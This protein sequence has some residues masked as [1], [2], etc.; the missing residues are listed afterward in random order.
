MTLNF[1]NLAQWEIWVD[2]LVQIYKFSSPG[3]VLPL[4]I[5]LLDIFKKKNLANHIMYIV[6]D[7]MFQYIILP[8]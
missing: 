4:Y 7:G 8:I 3:T 2:G 6:H 5:F 1:S